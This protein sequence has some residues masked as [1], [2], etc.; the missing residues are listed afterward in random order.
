M[1]TLSSYRCINGGKSNVN[2]DQS[3]AKQYFINLDKNELTESSEDFPNTMQMSEI[4][5]GKISVC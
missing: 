5:S 2:E 3:T 1:I 4:A